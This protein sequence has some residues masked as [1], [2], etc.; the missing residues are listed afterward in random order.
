MTGS[1][2][3]PVHPTVAARAATRGATVFGGGAALLS[4]AFPHELGD[5]VVDLSDLDLDR[6]DL[7]LVGAMVT[8][9]ALAVDREICLGWPAIAQA[10][11]VTANP[12]VRRVASIGGT[13]AARIPTADL[14]AALCAHG[15]RIEIVDDDGARWIAVE[16]Y[17]E[18][19]F[20]PGLITRVDFGPPALGGYRRLA[21]RPGPAPAIA[22]VAAVDRGDRIELRAGAV[23]DRPLRFPGGAMPP[24][25]SLRDDHRAS[26]AYRHRVLGVLAAELHAELR[27]SG[28]DE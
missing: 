12:E 15:A 17:L 13:I 10:A 4:H 18:T 8:I 22:A 5:D 26:A 19:A 23:A 16:D 3:R 21:G 28:G 27:A 14:P 11:A 2:V 9:A 24:V 7:P 25:A 6:V 20:V 1:W